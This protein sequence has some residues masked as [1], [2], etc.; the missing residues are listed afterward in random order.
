MATMQA[1]VL[2]APH[3]VVVEQRPIPHVQAPTDCVC[4]VHLA[5]LCG[6]LHL[7]RLFCRQAHCR[8]AG[9]DLHNYHGN[10]PIQR[11]FIMGHEFV[12]EVVETGSAVQRFKQG[13]L[14]VSPFTIS[15]GDNCFY[16]KLGYTS[17]CAQSKLLGSNAIDGAQ[18]EYIR[19]ELADSTLFPAPTDV[20]PEALLL[21]ADV[22]PT[23][24]FVAKNAA[25]M[26]GLDVAKQGVCFVIGCGP[27]GLCVR[28]IFRIFWRLL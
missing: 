8:R 25:T 5:A 3:E 4:R 7:F 24:Y 14:V 27:V 17:R 26:I 1:L 28:S 19:I 10:P 13:D 23:G 18:A 6:T 9:S 16:C 2:K 15:C 20:P 11:P 22:L 12:G 21:M